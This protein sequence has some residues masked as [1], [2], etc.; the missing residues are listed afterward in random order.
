MYASLIEDP[1]VTEEEIEVYLH[2][3]QFAPT[4]PGE[5]Y[6]PREG[7]EVYRDNFGVPHIY[8]DT[9]EDASFGMGYVSAE[10]RL[11]QM[12]VFRHAARGTLASF[13]GPGRRQR[14]SG[15][16]HRHAPRGLHRRRDHDDVRRVR[17][18]VR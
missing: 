12:D 9:I 2:P 4:S 10:D 8:G 18:Q 3:M 13:V 11:W 14:L 17:R 16:G 15:D 1:D 7:V 5:P 6:E